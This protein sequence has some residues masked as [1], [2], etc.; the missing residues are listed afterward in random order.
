M[1]Y[2]KR[3]QAGEKV[4]QSL[5]DSVMSII[6]YLPTITV[7]GD[8]YSTYV[9]HSAAGTIIHAKQPALYIDEGKKI[10]SGGGGGATYYADNTTLTLNTS[11]NVFSIKPPADST[12]NYALVCLSGVIQWIELED[13]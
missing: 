11:T 2:L 4:L 9:E 12:K 1:P 6:D 5:Y 8:N 13:C 10:E 7:R 3:P